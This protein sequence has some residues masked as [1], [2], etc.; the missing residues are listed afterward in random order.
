M[1][2]TI[3]PVMQLVQC[4]ACGME[5]SKRQPFRRGKTHV[6][7]AQIPWHSSSPLAAKDIVT[8]RGPQLKPCASASFCLFPGSWLLPGWTLCH[9]K[10]LSTLEKQLDHKTSTWQGSYPM[11]DKGGG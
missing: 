4:L 3:W 2:K 6:L 8:T 7:L 11:E 5:L 1:G 9:W 10:P